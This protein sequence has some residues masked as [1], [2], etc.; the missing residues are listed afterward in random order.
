MKI[1]CT[2]PDWAEY[3]CGNPC[4]TDETDCENCEFNKPEE[5]AE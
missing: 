3:P 5:K 4:E 2:C 1:N